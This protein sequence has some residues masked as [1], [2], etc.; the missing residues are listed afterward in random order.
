VEDFVL[1]RTAGHGIEILGILAFRASPVWVLAALADLCGTGRALIP[2]IADALKEEGLLERDLAF[3]S[4]EHILD[5][6]ERTSS[7]LAAAANAP[8][9]DVPGLRQEWQ[10]IREEAASIAQGGLPSRE[11][12]VELWQHLKG[13][14]AR[15]KRSVFELSSMLAIAT[16]GRLPDRIRWLS[17]SAALATRRTGHL[18]ATGLLDYYRKTLDDIQ[19]VG[20]TQY[21]VRQ[22][23]PYVHAAFSQFSPE[24]RTVTQRFIEFVEEWRAAKPR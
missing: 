24:R 21:A 11:T 15:Q 6:L 13:E 2:E 10:S 23:R 5:G 22:L 12:V 14:A 17:I 9:L 1:R 7:R 8:P 20:F 19:R 4:V 18:F 3:T 16:V